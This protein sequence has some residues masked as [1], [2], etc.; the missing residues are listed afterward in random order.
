MSLTSVTGKSFPFVGDKAEDVDDVWFVLFCV[1][2]GNV[3]ASGV[4]G[5]GGLSR[6]VGVGD[7]DGGGLLLL[8]TV[9]K[10][11]LLLLVTVVGVLVL[12][13]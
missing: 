5:G 7:G 12:V 3:V 8:V 9:I 10:V 2:I 6:C 1:S 11:L 13:W 4:V